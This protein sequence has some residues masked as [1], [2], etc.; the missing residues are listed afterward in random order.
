MGL[1]FK[2]GHYEEKNEKDV[3]PLFRRVFAELPWNEFWSPIDVRRNIIRYNSEQVKP[4]SLVAVSNGNLIGFNF[5]HELPV[6]GY[7]FLDNVIKRPTYF[8]FKLGVDPETKNGKPEY[9][10]HGVGT[11]L[12]KAKIALAQDKGFRQIVGRT[13]NLPKMRG[14]YEKLGY[15]E[16]GPKD[17]KDPLRVYFVKNL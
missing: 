3:I 4:V 10:G 12:L 8:G 11:A 15:V 9:R 2:I 5:A 6:T 17:P 14:I 16:I 13:K 1:N 7:E